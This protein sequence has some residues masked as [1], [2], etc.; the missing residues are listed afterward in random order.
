MA[1]ALTLRRS[2]RRAAARTPSTAATTARS[3]RTRWRPEAD[4]RRR[5][6]LGAERMSLPLVTPTDRDHLARVLTRAFYD[7]PV[8]EWAYRE[9]RRE[10]GA[11][12]L[13]RLVAAP[14][15]P[16]GR[17][18][19]DGRPRGSRAVGAARPLARDAGRGAAAARADRARGRPA[20]AGA[21]SAGS[22]KVEQRASPS[23]P[24]LY[25]A[26]L[27]VDPSRQG[28]GIGS[29]LCSAG[30]E[31]CDREGMPGVSWRPPRSATSPSTRATAF[32]RPASSRLPKGPRCG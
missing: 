24:H 9:R 28:E 14:A 32:A 26:V 5:V 22:T 23:A 21:C 30:L 20:R 4:A 31:L 15:D 27:G 1:A 13:L 12:A 25:L 10:R 16:S 8:V 2:S 11:R 3:I 29:R 19:D 18:L 17:E 6:R 7:D